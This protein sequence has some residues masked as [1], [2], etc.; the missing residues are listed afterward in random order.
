MTPEQ[1]YAEA[2]EQM[3][4]RADGADTW[5]SRAVFWAAVRA[6]ADTLGR[7]WAEI[8]ERWARLWAVAAEEHLPPIPGA[9]HVGA[10]PDVVAAEQ[11]LERMRAMVGARRR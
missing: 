6:G 2:C 1:A 11:N 9:A 7:P 8:A 4:R 3:P 10:L 5:S